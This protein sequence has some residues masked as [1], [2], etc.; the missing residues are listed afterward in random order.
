MTTPTTADMFERFASLILAERLRM[1]VGVASAEDD[2]IA[3]LNKLDD[4]LAALRA[5]IA[6]LEG[7]K[8]N[9]ALK[10]QQV[11]EELAVDGHYNTVE[12]A[13]LVR[14]QANRADAAERRVAAVTA[15]V[16]T[17]YDEGWDTGTYDAHD[18]EALNSKVRDSDWEYSKA[19]AALAAA[20]GD[21][22]TTE[23]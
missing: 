20:S 4:D 18:E 9:L 21:T 8:R 11:D 2:D 15:L 1:V 12:K 5:T 23:G 14:A 19:R 22:A 3:Y 10:L 17:A 16:R 6:R 13:I 7:E